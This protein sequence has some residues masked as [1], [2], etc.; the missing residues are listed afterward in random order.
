LSPGIELPVGGDCVRTV[1][2]GA[3]LPP[4]TVWLGPP[5]S[6]PVV[7]APPA[8]VPPAPP[9]VVVGA[10]LTLLLGPTDGADVGASLAGT[11]LA[12][13]VA[14]T[15][16]SLAESSLPQPDSSAIVAA[17]EDTSRPT[18]PAR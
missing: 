16:V 4:L 12:G 15:L 7:G 1:V 2:A 9:V 10:G 14:G 17:A 18:R 6:A 11:L 13:V 8:P 5:P 3:E